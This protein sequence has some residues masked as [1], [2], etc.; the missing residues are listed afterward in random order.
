M[1]R[2]LYSDFMKAI[3]EDVQT[4]LD[5]PQPKGVIRAVDSWIIA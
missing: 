1:T 2:T 5:N 3:L 4:D